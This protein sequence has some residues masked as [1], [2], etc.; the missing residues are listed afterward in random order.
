MYTP[1]GSPLEHFAVLA[2][3]AVIDAYGFRDLSGR[4]TGSLFGR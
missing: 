1:A 3:Q 4:V 2:N